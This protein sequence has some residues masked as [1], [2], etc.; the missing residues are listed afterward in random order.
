MNWRERVAE[1]WFGDV[2]AQRVAQAVQAT[3]DEW[4][5]Q[6]DAAA[7]TLDRDWSERR[8]DLDDA[9]EAYRTNPLARRIVSLTTDYVVGTGITLHSPIASIQA[10]IDEFWRLNRMPQRIYEWCDE[11]TRAGELFIV[12][13]TDPVSGASFVRAIPAVRIHDIATDPDDLERE[14]SYTELSSPASRM[15]PATGA[16]LD[17]RSWPSRHTAADDEPLVLHYAVNRPVGCV[18]GESDLGP[19]LPWLKRYSDWL[20]NRVR[21][22]RYKTA[23]LWDVTISGR[24]GMADAVRRKRFQYA[25]PPEPGS[26][27]VHDEGEKWEAVAPRLDAWDAKDDGKANR[28]MTAAGAGVPLHFLSEGDTATRATAAE[29]GDPTYRHY[30]QRQLYFGWLLTD[31]LTTALERAAHH[32]RGRRIADPQITCKFADITRQDNAQ[33]AQSALWMAQAVDLMAARGWIE[34]EQAVELIMRM[35][36]EPPRG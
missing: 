6:I 16:A 36:G 24:P 8:D 22:N 29:M 4:W 12:L 2:I 20:L 31:L 27:I 1:R 18:R 14:L 10:L 7:G 32:G 25:T 13:Q 28:L 15:S 3:D 21:L 11:L 5:T 30:Y 9:L 34:Q 26:V 19:I 35:A 23:F 17:A 33:M